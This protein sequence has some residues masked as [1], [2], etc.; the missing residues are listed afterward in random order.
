[1]GFT[2]ASCC[3]SLTS[4][5][6]SKRDHAQRGD[7]KCLTANM[8]EE[9]SVLRRM[10]RAVTAAEYIRASTTNQADP[11][12]GTL[13]NCKPIL[14][15]HRVSTLKHVPHPA[16]RTRVMSLPSWQTHGNLRP[17][18]SDPR[19]VWGNSSAVSPLTHA[20]ARARLTAALRSSGQRARAAAGSGC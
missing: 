11:K 15:M 12:N 20:H 4:T 17:T 6:W 3:G 13:H 10:G 19:K 1:M 18:P 14:L 2:F 5:S 8:V 16:P 7:A 9:L